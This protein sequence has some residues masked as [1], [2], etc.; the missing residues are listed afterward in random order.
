VLDIAIQEF[1]KDM[2]KNIFKIFQYGIKE[3]L[4]LKSKKSSKGREASRPTEAGEKGVGLHQN[5]ATSSGSPH[6]PFTAATTGGVPSP[7]PPLLIWTTMVLTT[8]T[9]GNY[10]ILSMVAITAPFTKSETS[11]Y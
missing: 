5:V 11:H 8:S 10:L 7:N 4:Q 2:W 1:H 9:S 6:T 3:P